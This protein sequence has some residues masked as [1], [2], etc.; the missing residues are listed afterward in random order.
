MQK[1]MVKLQQD[2]AGFQ[3]ECSE[4]TV[5]APPPKKRR[6]SRNLKTKAAVQSVKEAKVKKMERLLRKKQK[7][8]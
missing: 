5:E 1:V 4:E 2:P 3:N 8:D 6:V 7:F